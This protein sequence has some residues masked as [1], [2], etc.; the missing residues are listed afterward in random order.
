MAYA[1]YSRRLLNAGR[2]F[3]QILARQILHKCLIHRCKSVALI[4]RE[5]SSRRPDLVGGASRHRIQQRLFQFV[6]FAL[7]WHRQELVI[8]V[9][10]L[11]QSF[12]NFASVAAASDKFFFCARRLLA[13]P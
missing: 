6:R 3:L 5:R 1:S 4:F 11:A 13:S 12:L 2:Q 10:A 8:L 7:G 9:S